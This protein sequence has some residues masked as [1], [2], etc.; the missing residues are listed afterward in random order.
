MPSMASSVSFP[1]SG[2]SRRKECAICAEAVLFFPCI[3]CISSLC[4]SSS[5][6]FTRAR[7][8]RRG[9]GRRLTC[10]CLARASCRH[11]SPLSFSLQF[12]AILAMM[13]KQPK[14]RPVYVLDVACTPS[15]RWCLKTVGVEVSDE[16]DGA[17]PRVS[18]KSF[19]R[20]RR[21]SLK[22]TNSAKR[23]CSIAFVVDACPCK[24]AFRAE[25]ISR[26]RVAAR[27]IKNSARRR[28]R[29]WKRRE[30]RR[31]KGQNQRQ[32]QQQQVLRKFSTNRT[33]N[34]SYGVPFV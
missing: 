31:G 7:R 10:V 27:R 32:W 6:I 23:S 4:S 17:V 34:V 11:P 8:R 29:R 9:G 25:R 21:G 15:V 16:N 3:F 18:R 30:K 13:Q 12:G 19:P 26:T 22:S 28:Q 2:G 33:T 14:E 5:G 24:M 20:Y 1:V